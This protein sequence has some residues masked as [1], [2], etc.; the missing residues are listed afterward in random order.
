VPGARISSRGARTEWGD[1]S[2][3]NVILSTLQGHADSALQA[4]GLLT[5]LAAELDRTHLGVN[6]TR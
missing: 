2:P 6:I 5:E 3:F 4:E 1:L